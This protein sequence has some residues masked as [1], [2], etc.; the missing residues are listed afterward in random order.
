MINDA[1]AQLADR[2]PSEFVG[3]KDFDLFPVEI[4][5]QMAE[6]DLK[7]MDSRTYVTYELVLPQEPE[8]RTF[9]ITKGPICDENGEI[10]GVI[11]IGRETTELKRTERSLKNQRHVLEI[12]ARGAPLLEVLEE[13]V[14]GLDRELIGLRCSIVLLDND[15]KHIHDGASPGLPEGF[16]R[17]IEG[18]EIGPQAGSCGTAAY[19]GREIV[20]SDTLT[21]PLWKNYRDLARMYNVRSCWSRPI[22]GKGGKVLGTFAMYSSRVRVPT[23]WER[24]ALKDSSYLASIALEHIRLRESLSRTLSRLQALADVSKTFA[25]AQLDLPNLL[26]GAARWVVDHFGDGC[27]IHLLSRDQTRSKAVAFHHVNPEAVEMS[28]KLRLGHFFL[29]QRSTDLVVRTGKPV[30][31]PVVTRELAHS[32]SEPELWKY[33]ERFFVHSFVAVPLRSGG[34]LSAL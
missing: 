2:K 32:L 17:S 13:L 23:D 12:L 21:D 22:L 14:L 11:G 5:A 1:A 15:G 29:K 24:Q 28:R 31:I 27:M 19:F 9:L 4:A 25:E 8:A 16:R 34:E 18:A 7:V 3:K 30:W 10:A 20:V 33:L 26:D 6:S